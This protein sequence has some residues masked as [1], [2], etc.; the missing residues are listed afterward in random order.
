MFCGCFCLLLLCI[1]FVFF[2]FFSSRRR[3]TRCALVTGVQ[4][5]ALPICLLNIEPGHAALCFDPVAL[6]A[7]LPH[8]GS[9]RVEQRDRNR[10]AEQYSSV[11]R[12]RESPHARPNCHVWNAL[13]P[14]KPHTGIGNRTIRIGGRERQG[15]PAAWPPVGT[16][17]TRQSNPP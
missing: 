9:A 15:A 13:R 11:V 12:F 5:C 10:N 8:G 4:T 14:C 16:H 2:F 3:H 6:G 1:C 17:G 7:C